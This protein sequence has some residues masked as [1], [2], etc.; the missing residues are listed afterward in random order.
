M[1]AATNFA[2][3]FLDRSAHSIIG[4]FVAKSQG[5]ELERIEQ[6]DVMAAMIND[7]L[8]SQEQVIL[9]HY[10]GFPIKALDIGG[11]SVFD[12]TDTLA[13]V[14][15]KFSLYYLALANQDL[16]TRYLVD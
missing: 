7:T 5:T 12:L 11:S 2:G 3:R 13:Q 10:E 14:S 6:Y 4:R 9:H 15:A 1:D 8:Y 16:T